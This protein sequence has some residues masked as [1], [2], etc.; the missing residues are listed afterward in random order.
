MAQ[1]DLDRRPHFSYGDNIRFIRDYLPADAHNLMSDVEGA[2]AIAKSLAEHLKGIVEVCGSPQKAAQ[3]LLELTADIEDQKSNDHFHRP[4]YEMG[5]KR[6]GALVSVSRIGPHSDRNPEPHDHPMD[7]VEFV[8]PLTG[9][10]VSLT[11]VGGV[12]F[13]EKVPPLTPYQV[14]RGVEHSDYNEGDKE[15]VYVIYRA[16]LMGGARPQPPPFENPASIG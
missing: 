6:E 10:M 2:R 15:L 16:K 14:E 8:V 9:G 12:E 4:L 13:R 11:K 3:V 1:V 5:P 7:C